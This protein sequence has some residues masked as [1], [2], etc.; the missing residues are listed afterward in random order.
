MKKQELKKYSQIET[1]IEKFNQEK[2][3]TIQYDILKLLHTDLSDVLKSQLVNLDDNDVERFITLF[4]IQG[5]IKISEIKDSLNNIKKNLPEDIFEDSKDEVRE[6]C[7]DYKWINSR[8]GK[9]ILQIEEWIKKARHYL[10]VDFPFEYIYIGRSFIEPISLIVGGYV[11]ESN[12]K[13]L[14]ESYLN[15]MNPPI[16]IEFK[17][18][19]YGNF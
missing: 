7:A 16:A 9:K 15:K 3:T 6:I 17:I 18:T 5:K 8:N 14:V 10:S 12:T 19:V 13:K 1:I 4:P 11:K 2:G